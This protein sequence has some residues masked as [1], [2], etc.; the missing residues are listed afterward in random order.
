MAIVEQGVKFIS[1]IFN[2]NEAVKEF[3]KEFV[4]ATVEWIRPLFLKDVKIIKAMDEG[5]IDART[6]GRIE[7]V[8][9]ALIQNNEDFKLKFENTL[10]TLSEHKQSS[11][12]HHGDNI[13]ISGGQA[14]GDIIGKIEGGYHRTEVHHHAPD[15]KTFIKK[16]DGT[17]LPH[18]LTI[19]GIRN[20]IAQ[21]KTEKSIR[22]L[23]ELVNKDDRFKDQITVAIML[24]GRWYSLDES[25]TKGTVDYQQAKNTKAQ[26]D[27][28]ILTILERMEEEIE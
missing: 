21:G 17:S 14:G 19:T 24:S 28:A 18:E 7:M 26:I 8:L 22:L 4:D 3:Q 13:N 11:Y 16:D 27:Y 15:L 6:E 25:I 23:T 1:K 20:I 10:A 2:K 12:T 9:E 5:S